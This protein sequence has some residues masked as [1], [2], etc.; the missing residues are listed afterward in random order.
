MI[1]KEVVKKNLKQNVIF[2]SF[3]KN[4]KKNNMINNCV[5]LPELG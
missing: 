1:R 5:A 4:V 2:L 3:I